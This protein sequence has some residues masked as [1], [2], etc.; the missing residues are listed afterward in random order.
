MG[1]KSDWSVNL[2]DEISDLYK[3]EYQEINDV[4]IHYYGRF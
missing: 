4:I 1:V 2:I 3:G